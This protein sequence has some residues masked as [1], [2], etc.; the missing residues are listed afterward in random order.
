MTSIPKTKSTYIN[1]PHIGTVPF[2]LTR[3]IIVLLYTHTNDKK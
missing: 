1:V 3:I 2:Q